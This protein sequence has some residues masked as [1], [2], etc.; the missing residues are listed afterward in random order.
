VTTRLALALAVLLLALAALQWRL[1][2][3]AEEPWAV[4]TAPAAPASSSPP[5]PAPSGDAVTDEEIVEPRIE[6]PEYV[7]PRVTERPRVPLGFGAPALEIDLGIPQVGGEVEDGG[8]V[9]EEGPEGRPA[10][11]TLP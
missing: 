2:S 5:A 1:R 9:D 4:P 6:I 11:A 8:E 10:G 3:V 7:P